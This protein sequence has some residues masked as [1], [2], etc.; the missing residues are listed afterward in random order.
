MGHARPRGTR[1]PP[2]GSYVAGNIRTAVLAL[3]S[4]LRASLIRVGRRVRRRHRGQQVLPGPPTL[5]RGPLVVS[6][7]IPASVSGLR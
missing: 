6:M 1:I 5:L 4:G 7:R 2:N 3:T